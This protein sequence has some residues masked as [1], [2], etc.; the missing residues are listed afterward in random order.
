MV[1]ALAD[2]PKSLKR[3]LKMDLIYGEKSF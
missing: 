1:N 3:H 2:E